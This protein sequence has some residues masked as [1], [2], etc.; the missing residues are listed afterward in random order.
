MFVLVKYTELAQY[1]DRICISMNIHIHLHSYTH[2]TAYLHANL[3]RSALDRRTNVSRLLE[4]KLT[5]LP[6]SD[7]V[8]GTKQTLSENKQK[9]PTALQEGGS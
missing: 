4:M 3:W 9:C 6:A 8:P 1:G 5:R 7:T 2:I